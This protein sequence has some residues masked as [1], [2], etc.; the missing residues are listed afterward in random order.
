MNENNII[1]LD[2]D[3]VLNDNTSSY[4]DESVNTLKEIINKY[5]A[6]LVLITS[7][8][9]PQQGTV[10]HRNRTQRKRRD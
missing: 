10:L 3:G 9:L 4:S 1:F 6:K 7:E 8:Q 2:I 5:C